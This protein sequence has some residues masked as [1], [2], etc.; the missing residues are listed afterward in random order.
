MNKKKLIKDDWLI[1]YYFRY[2][3]VT[4][5]LSAILLLLI[6]IFELHI[7]TLVGTMLIALLISAI[8]G[9]LILP[10][11]LY[12]NFKTGMVFTLDQMIYYGFTVLTL[13]IGPALIYFTK[14]DP[15]LKKMKK[16]T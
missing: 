10:G 16:I 4:G 13:G 5:V 12:D 7:S 2:S 6:I 15:V 9:Y 11:L 8:P 3:L 1:I 14:Y